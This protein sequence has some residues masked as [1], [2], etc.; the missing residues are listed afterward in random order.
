M[1]DSPSEPTH[2]TPPRFSLLL[3]FS[4]SHS[5]TR[6]AQT[7]L[8]RS[9]PSGRRRRRPRRLSGVLTLPGPE[10]QCP[11]SRHC[12]KPPGYESQRMAKWYRQA[13]RYRRKA[14]ECPLS[15]QPGR[16]LS[17]GRR[18]KSLSDACSPGPTEGGEGKGSPTPFRRLTA[19]LQFPC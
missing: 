19:A 4:S 17:T 6:G 9:R 2:S 3:L 13:P 10:H 5:S 11:S 1:L 15:R 16:S 8:R 7:A 18:S 14:S 12:Q